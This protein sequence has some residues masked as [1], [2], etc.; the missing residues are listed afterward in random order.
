MQRGKNNWRNV[1]NQLQITQNINLFRSTSL[2]FTVP[3][4]GLASEIHGCPQAQLYKLN[5]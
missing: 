2:A 1:V 3:A 5:S 4:D